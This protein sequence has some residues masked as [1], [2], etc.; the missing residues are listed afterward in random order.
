MD[1]VDEVVPKRRGR[2]PKKVDAPTPI[3]QYQ[4]DEA[5]KARKKDVILESYYELY[6]TKLR[7]CKRKE[8]GTVRY[9][10]VGNTQLPTIPSDDQRKRNSELKSFIEKLQKEGR[11]RVRV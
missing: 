5:K 2:R 7:L 1:K 9:E 8:S 10:Y 4:I 3:G 6:G 11:L